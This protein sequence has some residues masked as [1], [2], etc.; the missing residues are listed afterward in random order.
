MCIRRF[1]VE[2]SRD[3]TK[4]STYQAKIAELCATTVASID[5]AM[6]VPSKCL[7]PKM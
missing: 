7:L 3:C 4:N 1:C 2:M 6:G 5:G